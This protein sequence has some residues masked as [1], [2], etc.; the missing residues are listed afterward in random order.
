M[1]YIV[2]IGDRTITVEL[3]GDDVR[4]DGRVV[5]ARIERTV[6]TPELR[7][8]I[9]DEAGA[10]ALDR[11]DGTMLRLV[12]AGVVRDVTV[13]DERSRHI[14]LLVGAGKASDGHATLKAPMP[15]MVIRVHVRPGDVVAPG[16]PL[17]VLEAMKMENE[18]KADAAG[19]VEAVLVEPGQAVEKGARLIELGPA[20]PAGE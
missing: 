12:H 17:L 3:D 5:E 4:V 1:K 10:V 15:G 7:V 11:A 19:I 8:V 16:A 9:D 14:R 18:F 20:T 13:E 6:G 2:T